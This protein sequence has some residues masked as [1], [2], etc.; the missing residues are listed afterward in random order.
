MDPSTLAD[1][2]DELEHRRGPES[3][4][5]LFKLRQRIAEIEKSAGRLSP[6]RSP[7]AAGPRL[8]SKPAL[9]DQI[10]RLESEFDRARERALTLE[11]ELA[12]ARHRIRSLERQLGGVS[13]GRGLYARVGLEERCPDFVLAAARTAFRKRFHPDRHADAAK[14]QA[15]ARF[16]EAEAVFDQI[17][18]VREAEDGPL[19]RKRA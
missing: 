8:G 18:R 11:G 2:V 13:S 16:K 10:R 7:V 15:E 1:L 3:D 17:L 19:D 12:A 5:L 9:V 6:S 14:A 4:S